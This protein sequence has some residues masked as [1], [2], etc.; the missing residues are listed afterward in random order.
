MV[1]D[2]D[3]DVRSMVS[4]MLDLD[5]RIDVVCSAAS[6]GEAIELAEDGDLDV[7]VMDVNMPSIDGAEATERII[8]A[9]PGV[10]VVAL[11]GAINAGN[12]TRMIL[13]G[14]V[15]Y[16]VKGSDPRRLAEAVWSAAHSEYFVDPTV[17]DEL[18]GSM[19]EIGREERRRRAQAEK[20]ADE[21]HGAYRETVAALVNALR[22]RDG[23]TEAHT[24]RVTDLVVSVARELGL[25]A[26]RVSDAEY[27]ALFH[28]IGKIAVPDEILHNSSKDLTPEQWEIIRQHTVYGEQILQPIGF[29]RT[30]ARIV[31][32]T[33]ERWDGAGYPDGLAGTAIPIESRI[34]FACDAYDAMTSDRTYQ[35]ALTPAAANDRMLELSGSHF[36]PNVVD[37]LL[38]V[39]EQERARIER[40]ARSARTAGQLSSRS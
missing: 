1:V 21:L 12:I 4:E 5:A 24:D 39:L 37:A 23:E 6:G 9:H 27:A 11:T 14:A 28:D 26:N 18:F 15:G 7:I 40:K 3:R 19:V 22:W 34:V 33:H 31:R 13:A 36:D 30:V 35:Q 29:L 10:R 2:D 8:E 25:P 38:R 16:V 20:L 17:Q 32:S